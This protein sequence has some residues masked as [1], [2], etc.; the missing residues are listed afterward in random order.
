MLPKVDSEHG[1]IVVP[2]L[3]I[4]ESI[5]FLTTQLEFRLESIFPADSPRTAI[6]SGYGLHIR[7]K[8]GFP[9]SFEERLE[10]RIPGLKKG[11]KVFSEFIPID[12]VDAVVRDIVPTPRPLLQVNS[13]S[14]ESSWITGRAGMRYRDLIP[15]RLGGFLIAS[16]IHVPNPGPVADYVHYHNIRFQ[17][18]FCLKGWARLVYE[19]QGEPFVFEA[20]DCVLQ[21]PGIRHRVLESS[22]NFDVVEVSCPAEH[23]THVEHEMELPN[24]S[25]NHDRLFESQRF[26]WSRVSKA[27]WQSDRFLGFESRETGIEDASG[28]K[29]N[30]R[31]LRSAVNKG[32]TTPYVNPKMSFL[33]I[34]EGEITLNIDGKAFPLEPYDS[35]FLPASTDSELQVDSDSCEFLEITITGIEGRT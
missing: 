21:P 18:I 5:D 34:V 33:F 28:N 12:F 7:L 1:E 13:R 24:G 26:V 3:G 9:T 23:E 19:D 32:V 30:A 16:H 29:V 35:I 25:I 8:T 4:S 27:Q 2:C 15:D 31:V 22:G 10:I 14:D 11:Q 6:L 17:L 20:G